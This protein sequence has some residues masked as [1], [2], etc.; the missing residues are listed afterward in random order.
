MNKRQ[1]EL[2]L[3]ILEAGSISS[4][5]EKL[6]V[7]Q[8]ALSQSLKTLEKELKT[9]IFQRGTNPIR[10]TYAG[11]K[12]A[13]TA[14][15]LL[16]LER[17]LER[18]IEDINGE[19]AGLFR[20]GLYA[21]T[22]SRL[23]TT[24]VPLYVRVYPHVKLNI[25]EMGS[26]TIE[27]ML[28]DNS[29]DAG[30]LRAMPVN[31]E[32]EYRLIN[33]DRIVLVAPRNSSFAKA[34]PDDEAISFHELQDYPFIAKRKGNYTRLI[35]DHFFELYQIKLKVLFE[36]DDFSAAARIAHS[37]GCLMIAPLSSYYEESFLPETARYYNLNDFDDQNNTYLCYPK[38]IHLTS[39]MKYWLEMV[40]DFYRL[41]APGK[42]AGIEK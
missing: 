25:M 26:A 21:G 29:L 20:F 16:L 4:A 3:T 19:R 39:Y 2:V 30:I 32:L 42:P 36:I 14:R 38:D 22:T 10:L 24:L 23:L 34:H 41:H 28:L 9:M 37:C 35:L 11:E 15:K 6:Y 5:A 33:E 13:E 31:K 18:E 8:P 17:N 7:T 1:A 27:Q 40:T 12:V